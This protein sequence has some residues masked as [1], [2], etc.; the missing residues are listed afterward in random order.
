LALLRATAV[1]QG[2]ELIVHNME[3]RT[4]KEVAMD[5]L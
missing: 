2:K 1:F 4:E 5:E 3:M